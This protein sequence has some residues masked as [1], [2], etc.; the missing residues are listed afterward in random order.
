MCFNRIVGNKIIDTAGNEILPLS[1]EFL[2]LD[3]LVLSEVIVADPN[4]TEWLL[5]LSANQLKQ[6]ENN[7]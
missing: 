2:A 6:R 5:A 1:D 3:E 7:F 4:E